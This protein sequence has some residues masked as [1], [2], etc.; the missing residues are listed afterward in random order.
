MEAT[1]AG[2]MSGKSRPSRFGK[3]SD[4]GRDSEELDV[5]HETIPE[6]PE[7]TP[8]EP[9]A[10]NQNRESV[11]TMGSAGFNA[12]VEKRERWKMSAGVFSSGKR[13]PGSGSRKPAG[14][15]LG[16]GWSDIANDLSLKPLD[17]GNSRSS[18]L[19]VSA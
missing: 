2:S 6:S 15:E 1:I 16:L 9:K 19:L 5:V 4:S 8:T 7:P 3:V 18:T 17:G 10:Q 12:F 14:S 11:T 13:G